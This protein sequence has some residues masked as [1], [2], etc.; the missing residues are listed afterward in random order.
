MNYLEKGDKKRY[1]KY[2]P[3]FLLLD[4]TGIKLLC[5]I[6]IKVSKSLLS[7]SLLILLRSGNS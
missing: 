4:S 7:T 1:I 3:S 6:K 2:K 5:H